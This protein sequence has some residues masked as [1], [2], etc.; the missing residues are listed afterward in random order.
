MQSFGPHLVLNPLYEGACNCSQSFFATTPL[1]GHVVDEVLVASYL[2]PAA[3]RAAAL[4][5]VQGN[6]S[7]SS[8]DAHLR[9]WDASTMVLDL[10][11]GACAYR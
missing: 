1:R 3:V 4:P 5:P 11:P 10:G 9:P 2:L 8:V 7:R 6:T